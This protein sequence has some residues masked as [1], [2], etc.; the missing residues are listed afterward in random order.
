MTRPLL[1]LPLAAWPPTWREAWEKATMPTSSLFG[2]SAP[3]ARLRPATLA[4]KLEAA[5]VY[6]GWLTRTGQIEPTGLQP[7]VLT[8]ALIDGFVADQRARNLRNATI[9]IRL[10]E[11]C[12][13]MRLMAPTMDL[14]FL[15]RPGGRTMRRALPVT[16]RRVEVRD[17]RELLFHVQALHAEG[18]AGQGYAQ[19]LVALRDAAIL[20]ILVCHGTRV[21]ALSRMEVGQHLQQRQGR[22]WLSFGTDDTKTGRSYEVPL[23][24]L[25]N[26]ILDAYLTIARPRMGGL[27]TAS[28]WLSTRG[29]PLSRSSIAHMVRVHT[30]RWTGTAHGPH[31][32]RKCITTSVRLMT[33]ERAMDTAIVLDHSMA[34]AQRH[35]DMGKS[36]AAAG[37]HANRV[38][39]RMQ[40]TVCRA[41]AVYR[42]STP[43]AEFANF[44]F[45]SKNNW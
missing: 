31:W 18:M 24:N 29:E 28:L 45:K 27:G 2:T 11:L 34:V 4:M 10:R 44:R 17:Q 1:A 30:E 22:Y 43:R 16:P 5:C 40:A 37:R 7:L 33:P 21:H 20:G 12:G 15:Q 36:T 6:L 42:S 39:S 41:D 8:Q 9:S 26:P 3:A 38:S 19:G 35:Y 32:L 23:P 13:A 25:L 14:D